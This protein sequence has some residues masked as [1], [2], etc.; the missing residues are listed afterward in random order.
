VCLRLSM[1]H[2]CCSCSTTRTWLPLANAPHPAYT[3][4]LKA[5]Q[6]CHPAL[7]LH[8]P[9]D[10]LP[11]VGV[12]TQ[13]A[14]IPTQPTLLGPGEQDLQVGSQQQ[15]VHMKTRPKGSSRPVY[16]STAGTRRHIL[17]LSMLEQSH[18][19]AV[20]SVQCDSSAQIMPPATHLCIRHYYCHQLGT[21]G[22]SIH[23]HLGHKRGPG[24][25]SRGQHG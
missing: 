15:K 17:L 22:V 16:A 23:K 1:S 11:H 14:H 2:A 10:G 13:G 7:L 6:L 20:S 25:G 12:D 8:G 21:Q 19:T 5:T 9:E 24:R 4:L 18:H 3:H